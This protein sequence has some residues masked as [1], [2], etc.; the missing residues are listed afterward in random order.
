MKVTLKISSGATRGGRAERCRNQCGHSWWGGDI[1]ISRSLECVGSPQPF[2]LSICTPFLTNYC[3]CR[4]WQ[5]TDE[6]EECMWILLSGSVCCTSTIHIITCIIAR[7]IHFHIYQKDN[8][9]HHMYHCKDTHFHIFHQDDLSVCSCTCYS[10]RR[11]RTGT[12][13]K[14]SQVEKPI[15]LQF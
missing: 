13:P 14:K 4:Y 12:R 8:Y 10:A 7:I 15:I 1:L 5:A 2:R 3:L 9:P 6:V 11:T